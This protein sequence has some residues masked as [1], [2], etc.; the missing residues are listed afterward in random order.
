MRE[1]FLGTSQS[2]GAEFEKTIEHLLILMGYKVTRNNLINGTQIDL[3]AERQDVINCLRVI[4][5]CTDRQESVGVDL[6]KEKASVLLTL[7]D[8]TW[9]YR[10]LVV[11]RMGFTAE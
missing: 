4:V 7:N 10:L 5:E 9:T 8:P 11:S 6:L 1:A 2:K 3:L